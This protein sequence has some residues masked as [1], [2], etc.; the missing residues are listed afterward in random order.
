MTMIFCLIGSWSFKTD[1]SGMQNMRT[2]VVML[3]ADE[4]YQTG[5][6]SKHQPAVLGTR[7]E[8]GRHDMPRRVAWIQAQRMT[9]MITQQQT[10][11]TLEDW[12]MRRYWNRNDTLTIFM[13]TL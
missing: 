13:P 4:M 10:F 7:A 2:S 5:S 11:R 12:K 9:P 3:I 1:G 6:V 8:M